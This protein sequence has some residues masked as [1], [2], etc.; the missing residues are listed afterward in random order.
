M[1]RILPNLSNLFASWAT[2]GQYSSVE[3]LELADDAIAPASRKIHLLPSAQRRAA[4]ASS[5]KPARKKLG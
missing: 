5:A 4:Q 1:K 2:A 3:E